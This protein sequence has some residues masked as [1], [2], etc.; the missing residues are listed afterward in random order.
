METISIQVNAE[1]AKSLE[2]VRPEQR[3]RI[4]QLMNSWLERAVALSKLQDTMDR[5]SDTAQAN[6]LTPEI[7][8]AILDE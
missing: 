5:M 1:V 2:S 6:G 7:L 8:Q 3:Q 4:Q